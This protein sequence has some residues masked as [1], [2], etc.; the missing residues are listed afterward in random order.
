VL[1]TVIRAQ[2]PKLINY[3]K[4]KIFSP[5]EIGKGRE[6]FLEFNSD[7]VGY[8]PSKEI[9]KLLTEEIIISNSSY[10]TFMI[11]VILIKNLPITVNPDYFERY[12]N[13]IIKNFLPNITAQNNN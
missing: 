2:L 11:L 8:N 4:Y 5:V 6:F 1:E 3:D 9:V 7:A 12:F 13:R 10:R